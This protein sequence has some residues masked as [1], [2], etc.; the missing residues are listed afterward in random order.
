MRSFLFSCIFL[1]LSLS[2]QGQNQL[3]G[4]VLSNLQEPLPFASVSL[5][6]IQDSSAITG[7]ITN[8]NGVFIFPKVIPAN[9]QLT[10]QMLGFQDWTQQVEITQDIDMGT[11]LLQEEIRELSTVEIV[12]EQS[13]LESHLGKKVLRIGA[14]LSSTGSTAL[15]ALETIPSVTTTPKGEVQIRGNSNVIVYINGK[16]TKRDPSSLKFIAAES[17]EK[18]EIITNP[19][20]QYDAEGVGGIINIVYKQNHSSSQKLVLIANL[21]TLTNPFNLFPNGGANFSWTQKRFSFFIDLNHENSRSTETF[22]S[23][24]TSH[25]EGLQHFESFTTQSGA[26]KISN[27]LTGFSFEPDSTSSFGLETSFSRWDM[28]YQTDRESIFGH[29]PPE[30]ESTSILSNRTEL[31]NELWVNLSYEKTFKKRHN[32]AISLTSGGEIET[33]AEESEPLDLANE[34]SNVQRFLQSSD[35]SESQRY[36]VAKADYELDLQKWGTVQAGFKGDLIRYQIF[37]SFLFYSDSISLPDN[38]FDMDMQKLGVYLIQKKKFKQLEY[39]VGLRIEHF[40]SEAYQVSDQKTFTQDYT[41]LFPSLQVQYLIND[42][43]HTIGLNFTRR[44]NRP[45]FFDLNPY[46]YYEDPLNLETGNPNLEPELSELLEVNYSRAWS[47]LNLDLTVYR[48][49]TLNAI[50]KVIEPI[51]NNQTLASFANIGSSIRNGLELQL[52]YRPTPF[53]KTTATFVLAK[54]QYNDSENLIN[55]NNRFTWA[56]RFKQELNLKRNWK[57][58]FSEL[59][60]APS[61]QIQRKTHENYYINA[62]IVKKLKNKR[63]SISLSMRDLFNTRQYWL[64]LQTD[65]LEV[66]RRS[67]WQTRQVTLGLKYNLLGRQ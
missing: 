39:A 4:Q 16:E 61:Y 55:F 67:K 60:R 49:K 30:Y 13:S 8:E 43:D 19:S 57:V 33:N 34:P 56:G 47:H 35:E 46:V 36:Y 41:R 3:S 9:Y 14:D 66:E 38:E 6:P 20:A 65:S 7:V 50:Q 58:E 24:R 1:F 40:S 64:S 53:F 17:I 2:V 23:K 45:G 54:H 62:G 15:E 5:F 52:E 27:A 48:R 11:L 32:L 18:I 31:E 22:S 42:Y 28:A 29:L 10:I 26:N 63:G 25:D 21:N 51:D 44:I 37:Q 12:A 59:Y